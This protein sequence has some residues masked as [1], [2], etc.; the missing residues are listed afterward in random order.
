MALDGEEVGGEE[1]EGDAPEDADE[2][3]NETGGKFPEQPNPAE[4]EGPQQDG[5]PDQEAGGPTDDPAGR[6][7][8]ILRKYI[9]ERGSQ[10]FFGSCHLQGRLLTFCGVA[11]EGMGMDEDAGSEGDMEQSEGEDDIQGNG[12]QQGPAGKE[13]AEPTGVPRPTKVI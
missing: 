10:S 5:P 1:E 13:D 11:D 9:F 4:D 12:E 8:A 3:V 2:P 6:C 7:P